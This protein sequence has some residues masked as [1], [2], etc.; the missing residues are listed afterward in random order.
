VI[1]E[2]VPGEFVAEVLKLYLLLITKNPENDP[3]Q[4]LKSGAK[5]ES[6][7]IIC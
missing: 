5:V 3:A 1:G 7:P 4:K 2:I 6:K